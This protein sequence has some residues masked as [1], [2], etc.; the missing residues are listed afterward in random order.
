MLRY[1]TAKYYYS[2]HGKRHP[3]LLSLTAIPSAATNLPLKLLHKRRKLKHN[4]NQCSS[5]SYSEKEKRKGKLLERKLSGLRGK[6]N[7]YDNKLSQST[8]ITTRGS[9]FYTGF[10][11]RNSDQLVSIE[12]RKTK[13]YS[14]LSYLLYW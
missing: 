2:F 9:F 7:K 5:C 3:N 4:D 12:G 11:K 13:S 14:D 8:S 6:E 1:S 10:E